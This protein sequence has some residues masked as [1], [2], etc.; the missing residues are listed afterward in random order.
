[1]FKEQLLPD[2]NKNIV[3]GNSLIGTD[4]LNPS[5]VLPFNK[6]E[7]TGGVGG[8]DELKLKPM[9]FETVFPDVMK[10]GGFDAV[11]GNPPYSAKQSMDTKQFSVYYST[12]E[13]KCDLFAFFIEKGYKLLNENGKLGYII[14]VSWMTNIYYRKLREFLIESQSLEQINFIEGL[15]FSRA[16]IDTNIIFLSK[17]KNINKKLKWAVSNAGSLNDTIVIRN[18]SQFS[19]DEGYAISSEMSDEWYNL[20]RKIEMDSLQ[21]KDISKISLGMKLRSNDEFIVLKKSNENPDAIIFGK[22]IGKY[23]HI[24]P[25]RYFNFRKAV[26]VG[27][28][29]NETIQRA[30]PKI[31]IQAI[32]N[33]SLKQR[34]IAT[35]DQDGYYFVGTV[36]A[37]T[38]LDNRF[39]YSYLLGL[40][41]SKLFNIYFKK[42]FTTISLTASFLGVLPIK[43]IDSD[44][45]DKKNFHD[46][47]VL[48][49]NQMLTAKKQ[50]QQAK[51]EGD[52]NYLNRKCE[53]LDKQIDELVYK[54]YGLTEE[55]ISIVEGK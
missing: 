33:L 28:T 42:R 36:N 49:V 25:T 16:N 4:I 26:I 15:V 32:R 45:A 48:M 9:D 30:C 2:L 27:G 44:Y 18:Y 10:S 20:K 52:K 38:I 8:V 51:T 11:V 23:D 50:L 19:P 41:N 21:L 53:T 40:L 46:K 47:I 3:C 29:S 35:L 34:I 12:V 39:G 14:P 55:E 1:M 13:Y 22:D 7:E 54:L 17:G 24:Q 37:V 6:G 31:F 43:I 5:F